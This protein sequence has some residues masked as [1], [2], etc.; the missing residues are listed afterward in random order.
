M[1]ID[2]S[3][4]VAMKQKDQAAFSSCYQQLSAYLYSIIYR[5]CGV[6]AVSEEIMQ[7]S[8]I[9]AF[10][11]IDQLQQDSHF[12]GWLKR[13]AFNNTM[14]YLR[15]SQREVNVGEQELEEVVGDYSDEIRTD[16]FDQQLI[17]QNQMAYLMTQL[18][19]QERLIVWLFVVEGYSHKEIATM[20]NKTVSFSK[21]VVCRS[22]EKM[23][24]F[25]V[26]DKDGTKAQK[27]D[28]GCKDE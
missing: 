6:S 10:T 2:S 8:F 11:K 26:T 1:L 25:G 20:S 5:I 15:H 13:I 18:S 17:D 12:T 28:V 3:I 4:V 23:R 7:D 14:T 21:S 27:A 22:L 19:S 24:Q 16:V 9:Q